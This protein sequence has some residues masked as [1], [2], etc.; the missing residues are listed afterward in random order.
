MKKYYN[1]FWDLHYTQDRNYYSETATA[2]PSEGAFLTGDKKYDVCIIGAGFTGLAAAYFLRESNLK[3]CILER[4]TVGWGASGRNGGHII[5][6][7]FSEIDQVEKRLGYT[8][9]KQLW[10]Y[11]CEGAQ[12]VFDIIDRHK[13][14]CDAVKNY[15]VVARGK[16]ETAGLMHLA[17]ILGARY[18]YDATM[19]DKPAIHQRTGTNHYDS[20][21]QKP[22]AGH[23]HPLKYALALAD[24]LRQSNTDIY[25]HCAGEAINKINGQYYIYTPNG[26]IQANV[27]VLAGDSYLG[28]LIPA[29]RRQYVLIR[30]AIIGTDK[31]DDSL[32]LPANDAV[33]ESGDF[34][35]FYR[36]AADGSFLFGGGDV[37]KPRLT[38]ADTQEK[39]IQSLTDNMIRIFPALKGV[40]IPYYWGGYIAVTNSCLPNVSTYDTNMYYANGYS[41]H[42]V[43]NAHIAG[44]LLAEAI[45][46]KSDGYKIFDDIKN[47]SFPGNGRWDPYLAI[48]GMWWHQMKSK[49]G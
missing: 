6:G 26:T 12:I 24:I 40:T 17:E 7:F 3:V 23:F 46:G 27:L 37:V 20:G 11:S 43:N 35:H 34:L 2:R 32:V 47:I 31:L 33:C 39:I 8:L 18:N 49:F 30:N 9:A 25:E 14:E 21:M 28:S 5:P 1:A 15:L 42:G 38:T 48:I 45:T 22:A 4:H 16:K 44:K 29:L 36:K 10:D 19:I 41:G 13:I